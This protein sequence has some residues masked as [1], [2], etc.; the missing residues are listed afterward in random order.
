MFL[1]MS[2][3]GLQ[4]TGRGLSFILHIQALS[5]SFCFYLKIVDISLSQSQCKTGSAAR[6]GTNSVLQTAVTTFAFYSG[7]ILV[8]CPQ[9]FQSVDHQQLDF[10]YRN[11]GGGGGGWEGGEVA[12][13]LV[14]PAHLSPQQ[15]HQPVARRPITGNSFAP[16]GQPTAA[17]YRPSHQQQHFAASPGPPPAQYMTAKPA[18]APGWGSP[19]WSGN[20]P[21]PAPPPI[22]MTPPPVSWGQGA[23]VQQQQVRRPPVMPQARISPLSCSLVKAFFL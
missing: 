13:Y 5:T 11:G 21:P 14:P 3:S 18:Y 10:Q 1:N 17:A 15:M 7:F 16:P 12:G 2:C 6:N 22:S 9:V 23:P 20:G 19:S 4:S 8:L